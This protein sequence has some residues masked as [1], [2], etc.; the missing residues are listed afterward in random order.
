MA[1]RPAPGT[2]T[3]HCL[4]KRG[5]PGA[6][7]EDKTMN[8]Q[9]LAVMLCCLCTPG[10]ADGPCSD[11]ASR[12]GNLLRID[13]EPAAHLAF[14]PETIRVGEPFAIRISLC[15]PMLELEEVDAGMPAH[16]HGMNYRP[17]VSSAADGVVTADGFLFHMPGTWEISLVLKHGA[18]R[19][20]LVREL[21]LDP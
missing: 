20:R 3:E 6:F 4:E 13:G 10:L 7:I 17:A 1:Q 2:G 8:R 9:A 15:I 5:E 19:L 12:D 18:T 11:D 21:A 16:G 14:V